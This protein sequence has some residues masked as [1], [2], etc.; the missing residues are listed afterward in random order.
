MATSDDTA[1][2]SGAGTD[3]GLLAVSFVSAVLPAFGASYLVTLALIFSISAEQSMFIGILF[4]AAIGVFWYLLYQKESPKAAI[5]AMFFYLSIEA[6]LFPVTAIIMAGSLAATAQ[7]EAGEVGAMMGGTA[8]TIVAFVV[9]VPIG[10]V[11]YLISSRLE[12]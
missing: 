10:I 11:F 8:S 5:G 4:F 9:G 6:F 12:G 2:E 1:E 3:W 7:T